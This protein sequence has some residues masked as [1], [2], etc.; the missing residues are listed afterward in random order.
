MAGPFGL[1]LQVAPR[2]DYA[3]LGGEASD[4]GRERLLGAGLVVR[5]MFSRFFLEFSYGFL[6]RRAPGQ[7]WGGASGTF[8]AVIGTRSFDIWKR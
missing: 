3:L 5:T 7:D 2:L 6:R 4:P 1:S 8:N